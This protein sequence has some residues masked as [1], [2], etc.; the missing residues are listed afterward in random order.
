[1]DHPRS[2]EPPSRNV[3]Q[4][5]A[6]VDIEEGDGA[7]SVGRNTGSRRAE[8]HPV[9]P[10]HS[11]KR[12]RSSEITGTQENPTS[13]HRRMIQS[14]SDEDKEENP[15]ANLLTPHQRKDVE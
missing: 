15:V 11:K 14:W 7:P 1:M 2:M 10:E 9:A 3:Q 5:Y 8:K 4:C 12:P 13:K 6:H